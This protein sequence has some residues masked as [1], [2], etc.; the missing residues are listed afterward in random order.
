M[1]IFLSILLQA[2]LRALVVEGPDRNV[3]EGLR[4]KFSSPM[5]EPKSS[6]SEQRQ[7]S[8]KENLYEIKT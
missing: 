1:R 8:R 6:L 7:V 3:S 2:V 5:N 4:Q